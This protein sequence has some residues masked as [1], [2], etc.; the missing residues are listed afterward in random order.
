MALTA[1]R[2][3]RDMIGHKWHQIARKGILKQGYFYQPQR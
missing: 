2:H 3:I 1:Q